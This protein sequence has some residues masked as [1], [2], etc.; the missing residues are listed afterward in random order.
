MRVLLLSDLYPPVIGGIE[1]HVRNLARALSARGHTVTV[2]TMHHPSQASE[3]R[4]GDVVVHRLKGT[5]HRLDRAY[6]DVGRRYTPPWPDPELTASL[7][8][9]ARSARPQ[10]VH[11]HNWL[12][13]SFL[14][15]KRRSGARLVVTLHDYGLVCAK[16]SL[17]YRD[18]LCDGPGL[19]KCLGCASRHYG[20]AKGVAVTLG[21]FGTAPFERRAVDLFLPVSSAVATASQLEAHGLPFE[22]VPNFVPDDVAEVTAHLPEPHARLPAEPYMLYV[23]ALTAHKGVPVLLDAYR[24]LHQPPPLVLIGTRWPGSPESF[25]VGVTVLIDAPHGDV[26]RAWQGSLFGVVPSTFPDPCPTVAMEAMA[27][28]R[29]LVASRLG[30]LLDLVDDGRSGLLVPPGDPA[31]LAAAMQRLLDQPELAREMGEAGL[32]K[33]PDFMSS[34]VISRI[35]TCYTCVLER[36]RPLQD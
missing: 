4:D 21:V 30:G 22:I 34:R 10:I 14:P 31:A 17:I 2:A 13:R 16:R 33:V 11:G 20:S 26:M 9:L 19:A 3:E 23:G 1:L 24:T 27:S 32:R 35:E 29:A 18:A 12:T 6:G 5:I 8:R 25:P 36:P 15:L 28:G 7:A